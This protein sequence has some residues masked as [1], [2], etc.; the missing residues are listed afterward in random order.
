MVLCRSFMCVVFSLLFLFFC[1]VDVFAQGSGGISFEQ[2]FSVSELQR[3]EACLSVETGRDVCY[4][5]LCAYEPGYLC[6]EDVL[7]AVVVVVGPERAMGVLHEIMASPVFAISTDGHLLSHIIGR[8]TSRVFGSSGENFLRCPH[9]FN[10]GCYHGFFED[11][12][13]NAESP[14]AVVSSICENM[15]PDTPSKEK[16]YCYHGAGHVFMMQESHNLDLAIALCLQLS[17]GWAASCWQGVFMENAGEREWEMKQKNFLKDEPLYPCTVVEDRFKPECY[18]NHHGYLLRHYSESWD[19]LIEVC[20]G[21]EGFVEYCLGGLGL[22]LVSEFWTDVVSRD[23]DLFNKSH[24]EKVNFLCNQFPDEYISQS[25]YGHTVSGFLNFN[26]TD[27]RQVSSL[28]LGAGEEY[29]VACF[30]RVGSYLSNLVSSKAEKE[31]SCATV[32]KEYRAFCLNVSYAEV[33]LPADHTTPHHHPLLRRVGLFF[34]SVIS[35]FMNTFARPVHAHSGDS[36]VS[37]LVRFAHPELHE[38]VVGCLS[39]GEKRAE[40]YATLCE[41]EPGYLCAEDVLHTATVFDGPDVGMWMLEEMIASP[42]FGFDAANEGHS[43]AHTVG[44]ITAQHFGGT[45]EVFLRC[46]T[47]LD[48]G[49]QHGFLEDALLAVTSPAEAVTNICESLPEKPG[50]GRPNCYHGAGHGVMMHEHYHLGNAFAVC[51]ATPDPL[52][53]LTGV[54]MENVSGYNTGRIQELYLENNSFRDD[55]PLAPCDTLVDAFHRKACYRQHMP[56]LAR[57]FDYQLEDVVGACLSA[58]TWADVDD[59]VFGFGAYGIYDGIQASFLPR[60]EGDFMDKI[61]HMCNQFPEKYRLHC[62]APA[63]DQSTVF[64]GVER[65]SDF[66]DKIIVQYRR[67]C[68]RAIG[69]RH[70]GLVVTEAEKV[71]KCAPVP[72]EYRQ[73]CIDP[74]RNEGREVGVDSDS[75]FFSPLRRLLAGIAQFILNMVSRSVSTY[76]TYAEN[77]TDEYLAEQINGCLTSE[78]DSVEC[79]A[80]LCEYDRGYFCA[81]K[82]LETVT[83][84]QGPETAM[85]MLETMLWNSP[86]FFNPSSEGHNLAHVVGRTTAEYFGSNGSAFIKCSTILAYGCHH[87]FFEV[88]LAISE[89]DPAEAVLQICESMQDKPALGK[90]SCYHGA[91]HGIMMNASHDLDVALVVCDQLPNDRDTCY[92]GVFMEHINARYDFGVENNQFDVYNPL[93]P[94]NVVEE[95]YRYSCYYRHGNYLFGYYGD[96][97]DVVQNVI[98][99]CLGAEEYMEVCL[100]A[101]SGSLFLPDYQEKFLPDLKGSRADIASIICSMFPEQYK[102]L[103]YTVFAGET[104]IFYGVK[105][106]ADL[107]SSVDGI[108]HTVC[109]KSV[110]N[111]VGDLS[112]DE[113]SRK[114]MCVALP[115]TWRR[116]CFDGDDVVTLDM[117][118]K[119]VQEIG[120]DLFFTSLRGF[121]KNIIATFALYIQGFTQNALHSRVCN[122]QQWRYAGK[123]SHCIEDN[124][125]VSLDDYDYFGD[126]ISLSENILAVGAF[127]DDDGGNDRGAVYLFEKDVFGLWRKALKI[128]GGYS[129]SDGF[130]SVPLANNDRFGRSVS[131]YGDTLAIGAYYDHEKKGA[132]YLFECMDNKLRCE[133]VVKISS[134][135]KMS[136]GELNI[137]LGESAHFG[138]AV[139]LYEDTLAVGAYLDQDKGSVYFFERDTGGEWVY[140][141]RLFGGDLASIDGDTFGRSV[142]LYKNVLAVGQPRGGSDSRGSVYLFERNRVG[143]WDLVTQF[144]DVGGRDASP[145]ILS[146]EDY[147]GSS[148]FLR[149][150]TLLVGAWGDDDHGVNTGAVYIFKKSGDGLWT[151]TIKLPYIDGGKMMT[152]V[153]TQAGG[154]FGHGLSL[155]GDRMMVGEYGND[156]GGVDKGAVHFYD[157]CSI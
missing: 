9:D 24:I 106:A 62:Y 86:F 76:T 69:D 114:Q 8:A 136:S 67:E 41:Y 53:C 44:R 17:D 112:E 55:N 5:G 21:A 78:D 31:I 152:D 39:Q 20:L 77:A 33:G 50:I 1:T 6:A 129:R 49:C 92:D 38:G 124:V 103:C 72:V 141:S 99:A 125:C 71:E 157:T 90:T 138:A 137:A 143:L 140:A 122:D 29:R 34:R 139:S 116:I 15:P 95:R 128:S 12:L 117:A 54:M 79:Y 109:F 105:E 2:D 126:A 25:C 56:Y 23:F 88:G 10:D 52:S 74:H 107:C 101:V 156:G 130:L 147:F 60:F 120:F 127:G 85:E 82:I 150:A 63:I 98:N 97:D 46:P 134:G 28:C 91:G 81:E 68:F 57:Y 4:A 144:T 48:Y 65:A 149:D 131:I 142:S 59:C 18:I 96:S 94:C 37:E 73:E 26:H 151:R 13:P 133:Q 45:G 145:I 19:A 100:M 16:S 58:T 27:L 104:V 89:G 132:V 14:V 83:K 40:C 118:T 102:S 66:C 36:R 93:A 113:D 32:P 80:S 64:Y 43:L 111:R 30:K 154:M 123:I 155:Y 75:P 115:E 11:T 35:Y 47:S 108:Y 87:G 42:L 121:V 135:G 153:T 119:T 110:I 148:V 51:D 61:I 146:P 84:T 3:L 22:M 70:Q 7:D